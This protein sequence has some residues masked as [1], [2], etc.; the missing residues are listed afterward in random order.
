MQR[1][2][3]PYFF[4]R[5]PTK[6]KINAFF[7]LASLFVF[8]NINDFFYC[9]AIWIFAFDIKIIVHDQK[10]PAD[11]IQRKLLEIT[12]FFR[13]NSWKISQKCKY[14]PYKFSIITWK[15]SANAQY[16]RHR[17]NSC[18]SNTLWAGGPPKYI[19][20]RRDSRE[21]AG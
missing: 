1:K 3:F 8:V 6:F 5:I 14:F 20:C 15:S 10:R 11:F 18:N 7:G 9:F 13:A 12:A 17:T 2:F 21:L 4:H 19:Y 16:T